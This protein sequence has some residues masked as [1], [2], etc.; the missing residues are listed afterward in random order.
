[1]ATVS[2]TR[3]RRR[4]LVAV[5]LVLLWS[6]SCSNEATTIAVEA[7]LDRLEDDPDVF[8]RLAAEAMEGDYEWRAIQVHSGSDVVDHLV[9]QA[10]EGPADD[11]DARE[12][13][14]QEWAVVVSALTPSFFL[15]AY[16]EDDAGDIGASFHALAFPDADGA[17]A[18]LVA[19]E[20]HAQTAGAEHIRSGRRDAFVYDVD[21]E[22]FSGAR[23][24]L[25][26]AQAG[27]WLVS[28]AIVSD[29]AADAA[30]RAVVHLDNLLQ[31][32]AEFA[33]HAEG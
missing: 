10:R 2:F 5:A 6:A 33:T 27:R 11:A 3:R 9:Q 14:D 20:E 28:T 12:I 18:A 32:L 29:D 26:Q 25:V 23:R 24:A 19:D 15:T 30:E 21:D 22:Y 13:A 8:E 16:V 7:G 4:M 31:V 17:A 1:M